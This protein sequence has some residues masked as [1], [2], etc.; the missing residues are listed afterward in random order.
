MQSDTSGQFL[1]VEAAVLTV[2]A[3]P[4]VVV[5]DTEHVEPAAWSFRSE[6]AGTVERLDGLGNRR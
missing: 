1:I 5:P 3:D 6:T 2:H 4:R